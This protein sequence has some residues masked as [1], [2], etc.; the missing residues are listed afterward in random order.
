MEPGMNVSHVACP[1]G[2]KPS[3]LFKRKKEYLEG[4]LAVVAAGEEVVHA[5]ELIAALKQVRELQRLLEKKTME[6]KILK[7]TVELGGVTSV[8]A[9]RLYWYSNILLI[10]K[11]NNHKL[12]TNQLSVS[13][14]R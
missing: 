5:S 8:N 14:S 10:G 2:I 6:V 7:E 12:L 13:K 4:S 9:K 1:H 3:L 11:N